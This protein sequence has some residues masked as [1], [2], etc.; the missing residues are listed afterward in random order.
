MKNGGYVDRFGNVWQEGTAHGRA[1]AEG[2]AREW[3]VQLSRRGKVRW[4]RSAKRGVGGW[5]VNVTPRG[6]RSH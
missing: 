1:H 5:Y 4:G 3:D 6:H 2:Y